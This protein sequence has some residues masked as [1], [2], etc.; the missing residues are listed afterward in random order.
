[1]FV[2]KTFVD[3]VERQGLDR[4]V[5]DVLRALCQLFAVYGVHTQLGEFLEVS[6][7]HPDRFSHGGMLYI[8]LC[9]FLYSV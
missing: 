7:S 1:M 2:L 9:V 6:R 3:T 4:D 5:R 8:A